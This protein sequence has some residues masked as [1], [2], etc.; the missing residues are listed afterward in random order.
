M[1]RHGRQQSLLVLSLLFLFVDV[2]IGFLL[3]DHSHLLLPY[4]VR[5][6]LE[7][8][9]GFFE[10]IAIG[11]EASAARVDGKYPSE[12]VARNILIYQVVIEA[13]PLAVLLDS[14]STDVSVLHC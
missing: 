2:W 10:L 3:L 7:F 14:H 5:C 6:L 11:C 4:R 13:H 1:R 8:G 9:V 12:L